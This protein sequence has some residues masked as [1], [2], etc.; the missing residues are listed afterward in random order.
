MMY[1]VRGQTIVAVHAGSGSNN[2]LP[3]CGHLKF[4]KVWGRSLLSHWS[5]TGRQYSH[6]LHWCHTLF[7]CYIRNAVHEE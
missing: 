1:T 5:Y 7:F 6:F 2:T 3:R 4:S